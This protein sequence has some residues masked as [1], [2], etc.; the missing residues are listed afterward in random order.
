M[1]PLKRLTKQARGLA[2]LG[3]RIERL[4]AEIQECRQV[5]LRL[6]EICDVVM[7]LL[8]PMADRDEA[9]VAQ[10]LE[11]YRADVSDPLSWKPQ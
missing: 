2:Q 11:R 6:A 9:A 1:E 7:E 10:I 3:D 5:N 8:L 4:E